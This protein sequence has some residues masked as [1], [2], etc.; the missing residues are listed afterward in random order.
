MFPILETER[1]ILREITKEDVIE[2]FACFSN[3]QVTR[4]YGAEPFQK[5]E[6]AAELIEHFSKNYEEKRG[7]RWGIVKKKTKRLIGT[8]GFNTWS[9]THKRAEIGYE[10]HPDEWRKGYTTEAISKIL[11][12]GFNEM[13]LTRIGAVVFTENEASNKLL[14]KLG[15]HTEGILKNYMYQSG[16]PHDTYI[17]SILKN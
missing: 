1:L 7:V 10:I 2:I 8:V 12:Y 6:Q 15:F 3:E 14:T 9:T 13:G 4:Y 17:Y 16:I 11:S 5:I